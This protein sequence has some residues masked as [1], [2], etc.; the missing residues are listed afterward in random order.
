MAN[1]LEICLLSTLK[2]T[3]FQIEDINCLLEQLTDR[4][5]KYTLKGLSRIIRQSGVYALCALD[6]YYDKI[7]G[8]AILKVDEKRMFTQNY[9]QGFIGDVVVGKS[10]RG[11]GIG[12]MLMNGLINMAKEL[13]LKHISLTSNPNNPKRAAAIRLYKRLGFKKIGTLNNSDYYRLEL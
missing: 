3:K 12:E 2:I 8:I 13:K 6:T 5:P 10:Y 7:A 4:P 1:K 11:K 9:K